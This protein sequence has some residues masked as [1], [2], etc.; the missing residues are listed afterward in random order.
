MNCNHF[1]LVL[2]FASGIRKI[3]ALKWAF[4]AMTLSI[5][6]VFL[7]VVHLVRNGRLEDI[8]TILREQ[9][10]KIYLLSG[11]CAGVSYIVLMYLSA[12]PMLVA[13]FTA[14]LSTIVIFT[15]INLWW[16]ISLHTAFVAGSV[17]I[18]VMLYD[19]IAVIS[20][21]LVPL[22]AWSR[23]E[24]EHHSLAQAV[25][26]ALLASLIAVVVLYPSVLA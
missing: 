20:V 13:V 15:C 5:L 16:K 7:L 25:T 26:G 3:D 8:F 10:T 14:G 23:I 12:P 9:R 17:T 2:S 1:F 11:L 21:V 6:P 24:L 4:I 22:T 19:W 18:L